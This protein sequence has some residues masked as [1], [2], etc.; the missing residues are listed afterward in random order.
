[1]VL[2]GLRY[3][4]RVVRWM[5]LL[6]AVA[7]LLRHSTFPIN[8]TWGRLAL[9]TS[10]R[11][12]DFIG[13]ELDALAAKAAQA[14]WGAH[15][16]LSE[17]QRSAYVLAYFEDVG[18]AQRLEARI[19]ALYTDPAVTD[20]ASA[21]AEL[22]AER[23]ALRADLRRRQSLAEAIL[24]G[25]V[26]A[27][28]IDEGF[29]VGGQ[30]VPPMA[31]RLTPLPNLLIVSP[32]DAIRFDY[33]INLYA[34]TTEERA[35]LENRLAADLDVATLVV[36]L[37][38]I[39]VYPAMVLESADLRW[40][41]ETFA[42]E[43]LH[44]YFFLYPLGWALDFAHPAWHINETAASLFGVEVGGKVMARYYGQAHTPAPAVMVSAAGQSGF[45][46][47]AA[48]HETRVTVDALLAEGRIE[49]AEAYMEERR[50]LFFAHGYPIRKL[51]QAYFAFYGGYQVAGVP[52]IAGE[53]P[54]G[55][56]VRAIREASPNLH[57]FAVALR[58]LTT[59]EALLERAASLAAT[60]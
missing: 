43:W 39:A 22:R 13:W 5:L 50:Q 9:A 44:H 55:P 57:A 36:P 11:H 60:P 34:M 46:F 52:G 25:Q 28:L 30:L 47:A 40:T 20:P 54:T 27:V 53:D 19:D 45:D 6:A 32:R 38:G 23:D 56:A 18:R 59:R 3:I 21:S 49:Q 26:A 17:A 16:F 58:D 24:E 31:M 48:M 12:F 51:N 7:V 37:G 35:A 10:D 33:G 42:H 1:M 8:T 41:A 2:S 4:G 14:L 29:G 15:P